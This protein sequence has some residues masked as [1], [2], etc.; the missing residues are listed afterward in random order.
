MDRRITILGAGS[1]GM[2]TAAWLEAEGWE[3][4]LCDTPEQSE[5]FEAIRRQGGILLRGG[6]GRTGCLMP[7]RLTNDFQAAL[8]GTQRVLVC[9]SAQRHQEMA[10]RIAPLAVSGQAFLLSPGNFGSFLFRKALKAADKTGVLVGELS[11]NLWACRRTAPGEVLSATPLKGELKAAALPSRDTSSLLEAFGE[12]FSLAAASNVLEA[13]LNSPNVV[14]HVGGAVLNAQ[15]IEQKGPR[16][17]FFQDGLGE[18]VLRCLHILEQERNDVLQAAGLAVYNPFSEGH[19]RMLMDRNSHPEMD[20]FRN[21]DGPS[22]FS[23]RYVSEDAACGVAML[24]SLARRCQVPVPLTQAFLAVA[25]AIN[26]T[27][28]LSQGRTLENLGLTGSTI[29]QLYKQI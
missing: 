10:Q 28:Y 20:Y 21:L 11:G 18:T 5:D 7:H 14:S 4:T 19:M 6:C 2:T 25:G 8:E 12:V 27:D 17:A 16:F 1:T 29:P 13:A 15:G 24:V 26:G 3:V 22:S 23:H 9:T